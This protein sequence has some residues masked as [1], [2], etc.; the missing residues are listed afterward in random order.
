MQHL[1]LEALARLVDESPEAT[2]SAHLEGCEACRSELEAMRRD[3]AAL[4]RLGELEPAAAEWTAL[5]ARLEREG[6]L[7]GPTGA[8]SAGFVFRRWTPRLLRLAAALALYAVGAATGLALRGRAVAPVATTPI[9]TAPAQALAAAPEPATRDTGLG[10][11]SSAE[12]VRQQPE[13]PSARL[14]S[15]GEASPEAATPEEA[16]RAVQ[17]AE[18]AYLRAYSRYTELTSGQRQTDDPVARVA[19]L[20]SIVLTTRAAL[21]RA[22]ADPVINGYHLTAVAQRD[23]ALRQIALRSNGPWF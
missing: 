8:R 16:M 2:E 3:A 1:T 6:L 7:A 4:A 18:E 22:P 20:E 17:S 10:D 5:E 13:A 9:P 12:T 15:V 14:A 21:D 11:T 23:A 19:A